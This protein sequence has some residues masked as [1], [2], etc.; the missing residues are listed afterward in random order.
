MTM[1]EKGPS[2]I[3]LFIFRESQSRSLLEGL[4]FTVRHD[5]VHDAAGNGCEFFC[6]GKPAEVKHLGRVMPG[7]LKLIC[8]D[9]LCFNRYAT[10]LVAD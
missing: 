1:K 8:D 5:I 4:G 9:V 2:E 10:T 6:C 3:A 7:S